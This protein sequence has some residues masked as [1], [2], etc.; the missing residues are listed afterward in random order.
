MV[1][2]FGQAL[3]WIGNCEQTISAEEPGWI[4][5]DAGAFT[6]RSRRDGTRG[7]QCGR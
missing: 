6:V 7:D 2:I 5:R 3:V 1:D 4:F